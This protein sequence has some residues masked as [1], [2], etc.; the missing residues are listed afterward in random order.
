MGHSRRFRVDTRRRQLEHYQHFLRDRRK[1]HRARP[2]C[3]AGQQSG[4]AEI[5]LWPAKRLR[6]GAGFHHRRQRRRLYANERRDRAV[7]RDGHG[8]SRHRQ[9]LER[10]LRPPPG[11]LDGNAHEPFAEFCGDLQGVAL[12]RS[13]LSIHVI[14]RHRAGCE[15]NLLRGDRCRLQRGLPGQHR[16]HALGPAGFRRRG[17]MEHWRRQSLSK[18]E[19]QRRLDE[20]HGLQENP[21]QRPGESDIGGERGLVGHP[22]RGSIWQH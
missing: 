6:P 10:K 11:Q 22:H 17:A 3:A 19:Q 15:R 18:P 5:R 21:H 8:V 13:R 14:V 2:A 16:E 12:P 1:G 4:P 9:H 7:Q 20:L